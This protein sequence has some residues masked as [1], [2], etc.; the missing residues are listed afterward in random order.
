MDRFIV[1]TYESS[2]GALVDA[3]TSAFGTYSSLRR[4]DTAQAY[5]N[6]SDVVQIL[7]S[8]TTKS[9]PP[10][11][12]N[13]IKSRATSDDA[14]RSADSDNHQPMVFEITSK[15][16]NQTGA[17]GIYTRAKAIASIGNGIVNSADGV[18]SYKQGRDDSNSVHIASPRHVSC[19]VAR[20]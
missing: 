10:P 14:I 5:K 19:F 20:T 9:P 7:N 1:G 15:I 3:L 12:P 11:P 17:Q 6:E 16:R 18:D 13:V 2:G 8:L 4:I